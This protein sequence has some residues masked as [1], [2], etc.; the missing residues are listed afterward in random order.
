MSV[1]PHAL[2]IDR[3]SIGERLDLIDLIWA[4]L[5]ATI[6]PKDVP[7]WHLAE[8]ELRRAEADAKP[9]AGKPWREVLDGLGAQS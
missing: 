9:G 2:G 7:A 4:S 3:L 6:D 1:D 8:L 5:P